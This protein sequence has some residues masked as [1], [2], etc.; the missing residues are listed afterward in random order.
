MNTTVGNDEKMGSKKKSVLKRTWSWFRSINWIDPINRW[1]LLL[2][3]IIAFFG[4]AFSTYGA[5]AVT[6]TQSFCNTCHEMAPENVTHYSTTHS[7]LKCVKC[8]IEPG[9]PQTMKG[10]V[11]ALKEVYRHVTRTQPNPIH[12][13]HE[14]RDVVCLRCHSENRDVTPTGDLIVA[15]DK[16]V[17]KDISCVTCHSGIAHAKV[18]ERGLNTND[19]F[20]YWEMEN[21]EALVT[22]DYV[23]PNMGTC[24]ECHQQYNEG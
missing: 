23:R 5:L 17:N 16:H 19:L 24:I 1:K 11:M 12:V 4:I 18:V 21:A 6:S 9:L 14:V 20:D 15:H 2:V 13:K 3:L 10:K 22:L 8:H 7:E